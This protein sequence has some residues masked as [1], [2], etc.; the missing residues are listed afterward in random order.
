MAASKAKPADATGRQ[1]EAAIKAANEERERQLVDSLADQA[2]AQLSLDEVIKAEPARPE[3]IVDEV[4]TVGNSKPD[5]VVIRV[6]D[7]IEAMT[8]GA[9]NFY[10]FR[11]GQ[12]YEVSRDLAEHLKAKGYLANAL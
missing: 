5:N 7:D 4:V 11:A 10:T 12:K 1:R 3:I 2:E 8:F 9:G 6:V